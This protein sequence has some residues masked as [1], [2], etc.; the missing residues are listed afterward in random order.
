ML[1]II[2][3]SSARDFDPD[4]ASPFRTSLCA[5][6]SMSCDAPD[7]RTSHEIRGL[8]R[9]MALENPLWGAPRIHGEMLK[10]GR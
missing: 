6:S 2:L 5:T 3:H 9:R 7:P 1:K 10:L 4:K 8:V